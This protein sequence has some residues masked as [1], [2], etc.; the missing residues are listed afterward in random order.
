MDAKAS[1]DEEALYMLEPNT[2]LIYA[3]AKLAHCVGASP[4]HSC[5]SWHQT[6]L[7]LDERGPL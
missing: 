4:I 7:M 1:V 5:Q 2:L 6:A 3:C